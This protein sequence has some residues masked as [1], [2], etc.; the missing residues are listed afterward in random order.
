MKV[1]VHLTE[2]SYGIVT[3]DVPDNASEEEINEKA[4][5]AYFDGKVNWVGGDWEI[6]SKTEI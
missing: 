3:I 1:E 6:K 2:V 4:T 5:Q